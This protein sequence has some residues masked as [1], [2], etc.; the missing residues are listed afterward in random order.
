M[1]ATWYVLRK[2][3]QVTGLI[4]EARL[5][6]IGDPHP[7]ESAAIAAAEAYAKLYPK[8]PYT[9]VKTVATSILNNPTTTIHGEVK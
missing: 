1:R 8:T 5:V 7:S 4:G 3:P 6:T 9:V 2:T